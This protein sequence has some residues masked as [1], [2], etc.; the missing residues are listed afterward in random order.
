LGWVKFFGVLEM[1]LTIE[2][3]L[4]EDGRYTAYCPELNVSKEGNN[5]EKLMSNLRKIA[6]RKFGNLDFDLE[7]MLQKEK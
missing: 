1:K 7:V 5:I 4:R 3:T 6:K 2:L